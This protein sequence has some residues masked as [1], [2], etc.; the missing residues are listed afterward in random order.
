MKIY[1]LLEK[2][3][4]LDSVAG[5]IKR[6]CL[7]AVETRRHPLFISFTELCDAGKVAIESESSED[8]SDS[9]GRDDE[10]EEGSIL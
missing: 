4:C 6:L 1:I 5:E 10:S 8:D 2:P 3:S 7:E 9:S